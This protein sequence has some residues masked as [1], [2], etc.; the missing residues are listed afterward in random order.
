MDDIDPSYIISSLSA[1]D[2]DEILVGLIMLSDYFREYQTSILKKINFIQLYP[3][4]ISI[5]CKQ[6]NEEIINNTTYCIIKS[7]SYVKPDTKSAVKVENPT[8][9]LELIFNQLSEPSYKSD[10]KVNILNALFHMILI[11]LN[12]ITIFEFSKFPL[13]DTI[14]QYYDRFD[15]TNKLYSLKML[16]H[17]WEFYSKYNHL[18]E[19][20]DLLFGNKKCI[21]FLRM[22]KGTVGSDEGAYYAQ[23]LSFNIMKTY[24]IFYDDFVHSFT[25]ICL[26]AD[27][28]D[29]SEVTSI[30]Q[31]LNTLF[32]DTDTKGIFLQDIEKLQLDTVIQKDAYKTINEIILIFSTSFIPKPNIDSI[33][34]LYEPEK[35]LWCKEQNISEEFL[36]EHSK[37]MI[38]ITKYL[39]INHSKMK[40]I[41]LKIFAAFS[42]YFKPT[43]DDAIL[44]NLAFD[45]KEQEFAFYIAIILSNLNEEQRKL[46]FRANI[47]DSLQSHQFENEKVNNDYFDYLDNKVQYEEFNLPDEI[48]NA[49][50]LKDISKSIKNKELLFF[51]FLSDSNDLFNIC[52]DLLPM[53]DKEDL[54][55]FVEFIFNKGLSSLPLPQN[56]KDP[57]PFTDYQELMEKSKRL[58]HKSKVFNIELYA[59]IIY[60]EVL[61]NDEFIENVIQI[62][63]K[64]NP[65]FNRMFHDY[66]QV[67]NR[68]YSMAILAEELNINGFNHFNYK[69][70]NKW[71]DPNTYFLKA[72]LNNYDDAEKIFD[73][74]DFVCIQTEKQNEKSSYSHKI[75]ERLDKDYPIPQMNQFLQNLLELLNEIYLQDP[76]INMIY[77]VFL[78]RIIDQL[79][80]PILTIGVLS[81]C[82]KFMIKYPFLFSFDDRF[83]LFKVLSS[84]LSVVTNLYLKRFTEE[85]PVNKSS[86]TW[87]MKVSRNNLYEEGMKIL[88][89]FGKYEVFLEFSFDGETGIGIGP[90]REFFSLMSKE[91]CLKKNGMW[92]TTETDDLYSF[93][94][95][96]L[97]PIF[98]AK[99]E[100]FYDLGIFVAKAMQMDIILDIPFNPAFFDLVFNREIEISDI[101]QQYAKSLSIPENLYGLNFIYPICGQKDIEM[102]PNGENIEVNP[103]NVNEYIKLFK[104]FTIGSKIKSKVDAF[105]K[106]FNE[107]FD[108]ELL[109]Y[110]NS[111]EITRIIGG[112][113]FNLSIEDLKKYVQIGSGFNSN[114]EQIK[115]LFEIIVEM[116]YR[117]KI[118]FFQ[119][120]TGSSRLPIGGISAIYPP[121]T[122]ARRVLENSDITDDDPLPTVLTCTHYF[123]LPAYST[124]QIM[125]EKLMKAVMEGRENFTQT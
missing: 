19:Y 79:S 111:S 100:L 125:K 22:F 72:L 42:F 26:Q 75:K 20:R 53:S 35:Y 117:E 32:V 55:I 27:H 88:K 119:F 116:E 46:L 56:P 81:T 91:F 28:A 114:S 61:L 45:A 68:R 41:A 96:G 51:D 7:D 8:Q 5:L 90:N 24:H 12:R 95:K 15:S 21:N 80:S 13:F 123:K 25:I 57:L 66:D 92:R 16:D 2:A 23:K 64:D 62:E 59:P 71:I 99:D 106:G 101:D 34:E 87:H 63:T 115:H 94:E 14:R 70:D 67:F 105:V 74:N 36:K 78:D 6:K 18:I 109:N 110:F 11:C 33:D 102:I 39:Y 77:S 60:T 37:R 118:L 3:V 1:N 49:E 84:E 113:G 17:L 121:L 108:I 30:I 103:S 97:F 31:L 47:Y 52:W 107:I 9:I 38:E 85:N 86:H 29:S 44:Y 48:L 122:V 50:S 43:F 124:K 73:S 93:N 4:L 40:L 58:V 65:E 10:T 83:F 104:E 98:S 120:I 54:E 89:R 76:T 69:Y 112:E 82:T